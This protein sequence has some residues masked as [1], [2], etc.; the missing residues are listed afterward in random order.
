M[1]S[2]CGAPGSPTVLPGMRSVGCGPC[3]EQQLA[4][5]RARLRSGRA[6][7]AGLGVSLTATAQPPPPCCPFDTTRPAESGG[8]LAGGGAA[9]LSHGRDTGVV[10]AHRGGRHR[11]RARGARWSPPAQRACLSSTRGAAARRAAAS[12]PRAS[13]SLPRLRIAEHAHHRLAALPSLRPPSSRATPSRHAVCPAHALSLR[14]PARP[15]RAGRLAAAAAHVPA[16]SP[17]AGLASAPCAVRRPRRLPSMVSAAAARH[18]FAQP[19]SHPSRRRST[20]RTRCPT[21][22]RSRCSSPSTPTCTTASSTS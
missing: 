18:P 2:P 17:G 6:A 1:R 15:S 7:D 14:P 10:C 9:S 21:L 20:S 5:A 16:P 11:R 8:C 13:P 12:P 19:R 3:R 4:A 22:T